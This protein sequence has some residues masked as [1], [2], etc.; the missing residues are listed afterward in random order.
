MAENVLLLRYG[1]LG[2]KGKN[3]D[4]FEDTLLRNVRRALAGMQAV[5]E[6]R[7][8][9]VVVRVPADETEGAVAALQRVFGL[10]S[11]SPA[12]RT[13]LEMSEILKAALE[14]VGT[15]VQPPFTFKVE[16]RRSEKRFPHTSPDINRL[17]GTHIL[18]AY[19]RRGVA[20]DVHEPDIVVHVEVRDDGAYVF[21]RVIPGP[22]GLPLGSGG[23]AL[24]LLSGGIDS[25]VAGW[26][27]MKRGVALEAIHFH[28]FPF[29]SE[30]SKQKAVDLCGALA[31]WGLPVP[32]HVCHFGEIQE[33]IGRSCPDE[34]TTIVMRRMMLRISE[35]TAVA[36]GCQALV[37]GESVGQ[38][39]SQTLES[40]GVVGGVTAMTILRPLCGL[41]KVEIIE[42]AKRIGTFDI[43]TRPF[44]DCCAMFVPRHPKT[45]PRPDQAERA[46]AAMDVDGL[47]ERA[48]QGI[49]LITP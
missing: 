38:V 12:A 13:R 44:E 26:F 15:R 40:M 25:P 9:R 3:R 22:G 48:L 24:L 43:S 29:T 41:D 46:E 36:R 39:A 34:M 16:A 32:L 17:V 30:K 8:G 42:R 35:R 28:S 21:S 33:E 5:A 31:R 4:F 19:G 45:K 11:L 10:V 2:L 49:E 18:E 7:F 20:V 37:T 14:E 47:V 6:K 27:M 1:E 23:K